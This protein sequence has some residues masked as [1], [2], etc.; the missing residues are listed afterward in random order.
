MLVGLSGLAGSGKDTAADH[1]V[2]KHN[3]VKVSLADPLKRM[4]RDAFDFT[5]DQLWGPSEKRNAPD[6]RYRRKPTQ[7]MLHGRDFN[8]TTDKCYTCG[9][10]KP[11][12]PGLGGEE[13]FH[14]LTPRYA[15]QK[16]GTEWGRDC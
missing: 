4:C 1:L 16:L 7:H 3:F 9:A 14:Y 13:C 5:D 10:E 11:W 8:T 12:P 6:E 2:A 15:L